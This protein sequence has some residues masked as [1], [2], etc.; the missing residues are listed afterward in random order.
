MEEKNESKLTPY[1]SPL[2]AWAL[3]IG[4]SIGWG[5]LVITSSTYLAQAGP[6]GSSLGM[7]IGSLIMLVISVNYH[8]MMNCYP[9]A[10]G[11]YTYAK[12][13]FGYDHGFLLS[14]FLCLTYLAM[15]W[16]N[17]TALPLF[18]RFFI[19]DVLEFGK[20]YSI[21]GYDVYLGEVLLT[22]AAIL[23]VAWVCSG[24][25]K[26]TQRIMIGLAGCFAAG[27]TVCFLGALFGHEHSFDPV[28]IPD[29]SALGQVLKIAVIS[30]WAFIGFENI[31]HASEEFSFRHQKSFRILASSVIATAL[32]YIFA[33]VLSTTAFPE[34]YDSWLSYIRDLGNLEGI[35]GLPPFYATQHYLG[36]FGIGI[37]MAAL[38]A[39]V[40][41]SLIGNVLALSRLFYAMGKD[42]ILPDRFASLNGKGIPGKAIRLIALVSLVIPFVGRTAIGWIVDITT[43]GATLIYGFV[44]A[45]ARRTAVLHEDRTEIWTGTAGLIIMIGFGLYLLLPNLFTAGSM[46]TETYFLFVI[47]SILGFIYFRIILKRDRR[48][49]F[50]QSIIV[51]IAL[52]SLI[53]FVSL[54]WMSQSIMNT[55]QDSITAVESYYQQPGA[56]ENIGIG[57]AQL[58]NIYAV[59]ARSM[60]VVVALFSV[61]LG[62]LLTNYALMSRKAQES[63]TQL[64]I[65][66]NIANTDPLTGVKSKHAYTDWER[67]LNAE[68]ADGTAVPFAMVVCD[69]NGLKHINDTLGH[70]AGDAYIQ[71]ACRMVCEIFLHSPVFRI[72]GDEFTVC[73]QGRDYENREELMKDLHDQ[74]LA[75]ISTGGAVISGGMSAFRSGQDTAVRPVF[76]RADARMYAEKQLLKQSGAKTR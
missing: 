43:I 69:V 61:A 42:R 75:H 31:S 38:L 3:A 4:T 27:I 54:V 8:Y 2:G 36:S 67:D 48:N 50:G 26:G 10:G 53:L 60:A 11:A 45:C 73:L 7:V 32:L 44:S 16:A 20:L 39:L 35:E 17:A 6:L 40:L 34:R 47:W 14:W 33:T 71:E 30:P 63:A 1:V 5:S 28:L 58:R 19:G 51:W 21:F 18:C 13:V 74:S 24:W 59:N 70:Q 72:G 62:I 22:M 56:R 25:K 68:I 55:A 57:E 37:L 49:R 29:T 52:L 64:G 41:S 23:L 66:R 12:E 15:L 9:E 46:A 76:E 65:I